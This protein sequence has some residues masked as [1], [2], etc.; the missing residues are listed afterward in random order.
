VTNN[1]R[2]LKSDYAPD[3]AVKV[4]LVAVPL[5]DKWSDKIT[6]DAISLAFAEVEKRNE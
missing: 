5:G 1:L 2:A 3:K 6:V 4:S